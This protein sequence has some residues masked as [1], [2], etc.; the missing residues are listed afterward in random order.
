MGTAEEEKGRWSMLAAYGGWLD[1][2]W[3]LQHIN[4]TLI[5]E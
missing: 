3:F 2:I 1:L 5:L 4:S